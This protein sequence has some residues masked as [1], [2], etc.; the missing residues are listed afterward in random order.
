[1][2]KFWK[3]RKGK[4]RRQKGEE[5]K[6][7]MGKEE[8]KELRNS[9]WSAPVRPDS[10]STMSQP[11]QVILF[12]VGKVDGPFKWHFSSVFC[13]LKL[14]PERKFVPSTAHSLLP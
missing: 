7:E 1:V 9:E 3:W 8:R 6:G 10:D 2:K 12:T 14:L 13:L 4:G 5:E 11:S